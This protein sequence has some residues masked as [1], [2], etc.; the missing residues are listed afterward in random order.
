[1][2]N[3]TGT[4]PE[5]NY[6]KKPVP[7]EQLQR[8]VDYVRAQRILSFMLQNGLISLSEF[9]KITS[10]NRKSFSPALAQIMPEI[11]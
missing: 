10:L 9:N 2:A 4:I 11:R 3:I 1:M 6:E 8:E 5:I 7:Q